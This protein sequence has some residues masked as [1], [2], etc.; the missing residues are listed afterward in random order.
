MSC[1]STGAVTVQKQLQNR[2][3]HSTGVVVVQVQ[4]QYR[5]SHSTGSISTTRAVAVQEQQ[6][7]RSSR[8]TGA[9][10]VQGAIA[11]AVAVSGKGLTNVAHQVAKKTGNFDLVNSFLFPKYEPESGFR[12]LHHG[13]F[14]NSGKINKMKKIEQKKKAGWETHKEKR[15]I[16][17][18]MHKITRWGKVRFCRSFREKKGKK[19][20]RKRKKK[21]KK[22]SVKKNLSPN[23]PPL[24]IR[25][26]PISS[27]I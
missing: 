17:D 9:V 6:Q 10:A 21:R 22:K 27:L 15:P 19:E 3:S 25:R 7:Y 2:S 13:K 12:K 11:V 16:N 23:E 1:H 26:T 14:T 4:S 18:D 20:K 5:S 8:S 24:R